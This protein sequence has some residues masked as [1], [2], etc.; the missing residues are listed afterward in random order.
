M[1]R[2]VTEVDYKQINNYWH[3]NRISWSAVFAG[4]IITTVLLLVFGLLGL[5]IGMSTIDHINEVETKKGI[6]LGAILWYTVSSLTAVFFGSCIAGYFSGKVIE[7]NSQTP[8]KT[9]G[10]IHGI[11]TWSLSTLIGFYIVTTTVGSIISGTAVFLEKGLSTLGSSAAALG[12][13]AAGIAKEKIDLM[14]IDL[15]EILDDAKKI[16]GQEFANQ[17]SNLSDT[18]LQNNIETAINELNKVVQ[19]NT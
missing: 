14:G 15:T 4:V 5:G 19:N 7:I 9:P 8:S 6:G 16:F 11:L 17:N 2:T 1:E 10:I 18:A 12:P 3:A 13:Y